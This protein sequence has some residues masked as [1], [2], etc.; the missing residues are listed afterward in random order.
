[1]KN[2][3]WYFLIGLSLLFLQKVVFARE[4]LAR[5]IVVFKPEVS[6]QEKENLFTSYR[7]TPEKRLGLINGATVFL[8]R[9]TT[10]VLAAD[11]RVLRIDP[12]IEVFAL[13]KQPAN[14]SLCDRYP[15]LPWCRPTPTPT[16][17]PTPTPTP[18]A[19]NSQV[20]PWGVA[21]IE[22][23]KVWSA[24]A[25]L[26]IKVA[27]L[28]TG[29]NRNH[30]DLDDNLVGCLNFINPRKTCEDDNGH[31][32][33][34]VG[35]IGAENNN[36]GVVGVAPQAKI[37]A[38]KVLDKNGSGYLSDL[39]EALDWAVSNK[40]GVV[41]LSLGTTSDVASF[42]EA[43]Q[44]TV[45]AGIAVVAAAGNSG[46]DSNSV[47][48]PAKYPE[49]I[50]VSAIDKTKTIASWSSRGPEVDLAAPGVEI[51]STY[52]NKSYKTLSGTSMATPHV[53]GVVTLLLSM[54]EKCDFDANGSC[55]PAEIQ[56]RFELASED[57]G[58]TG[59]D[60]LYGS[61]LVNAY[62]ALF[63]P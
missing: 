5:K 35:I 48:Y 29:V 50:A 28:D 40:V 61:G 36:F 19:E 30:P 26:G 16:S 62:R 39:I 59:K 21:L 38:L 9:Q 8:S 14:L 2:W 27:V 11:P 42:H 10:G 33:H 25:G 32:T 31:G 6:Q 34:V 46:P 55:S 54:P 47:L 43:I 12:D 53:T 63:A 17:S 1:M 22:A 24:T 3:F 15:W 58:A 7:L 20:L 49:V 4:F 41:N 44:K 23:D 57:L 18:V 56:Q 60:D 13:P 37:Y 52:K 51:Y 45:R